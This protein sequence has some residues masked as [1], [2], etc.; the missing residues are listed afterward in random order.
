MIY[1][2]TGATT[3]LPVTNG[4]RVNVNAS[5]TGTITIKDAGTIIGVLTNPGIIS[6]PYIGFAGIPTIVT[7][8][9]CDVTISMLN[10]T[11]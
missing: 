4:I 5:L 8:T 1:I 2:T 3:T 6:M 11:E 7:S 9:T 10:R